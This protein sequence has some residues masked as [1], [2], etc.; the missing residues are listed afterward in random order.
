MS[1][2]RWLLLAATSLLL[3]AAGVVVAWRLNHAPA[4]RTDEPAPA[5]NGPGGPPP[6]PRLTFATPYRNV[7]P[8]VAYVGSAICAKCHGTIAAHFRRH[9]MGRSAASGAELLGE[10]I[11]VLPSGQEPLPGGAVVA[12]RL[13]RLEQYDKRRHD[14]FE[15]LG[16]EHKV[17]PRGGEIIHRVS[18]YDD[19][20]QLVTALEEPVY[21][22]LGSGTRGRT[23]VV[24]RGDALFESPISWYSQK[25]RWD[26]SPAYE[27][28]IFHQFERPITTECLF[29]HVNAVDPIQGTANRYRQPLVREPAIGCERCHGPGEL[30]VKFRKEHPQSDGKRD[31]TIVDPAKLEPTLRESV[32]EQCHLQG[33]VPVVRAGRQPF[34]YRPGL[35]YELFWSVFVPPEDQSDHHKS[36]TT[37]EQMHASRCFQKSQGALGC[38][39]CHDPHE[40]PTPEERVAYY[41]LRCQQCHGNRPEKGTGPLNA[42]VP[43]PS[44]AGRALPHA[45]ECS[46]DVSV[47]QQNG[48]NCIACH[49]APL[50]S[51]DIPHTANSD[52]RV[53]RRP[54]PT[55]GQ[56]APPPTPG[57]GPPLVAFH[58]DRLS[59][60]SRGV[61]RDLG[62]AL[63]QV[64]R[65][66][67][68]RNA[69]V[70]AVSLLEAAVK[71]WPDDRDALEALTTVLGTPGLG[72][73]NEA[74]AL[75]DDLANRTPP[76]EK[77]LLRAAEVAEHLERLPKATD[78]Y[79]RALALNSNRAET[80]AKLGRVLVARGDWAGAVPELDAALRLNP[81]DTEARE[82]LV[83]AFIKLGKRDRAR[84][85]FDR[86]L[87]FNPPKPDLLKSWFED[88][89]REAG[90]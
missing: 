75:L 70:A 53:L 46:E 8:D 16:L 49:M 57:G 19:R 7:R 2:R 42:G 31:F 35:P 27:Q 85:E 87:R 76:S 79:R 67:R 54:D 5:A 68:D 41:R 48:D 13:A 59:P 4:E 26:L 77:I 81:F 74:I 10:L 73:S 18:R 71:D 82:R 51:S 86:L 50:T 78:Y 83:Y 6:D 3:I 89:V 88:H 36:V 90:P 14:P 84:E 9:P 40:L 60:N 62:I 28:G 45:P 22:A 38:I 64:A 55:R 69:A 21:L 72:R 56:P 61:N 30:H 66:Q 43:S 1:T 11:G 37:V 52:H 34:D 29:C 12:S 65:Y 33:R 44:P 24:A 20:H 47:R 23:Y 39:S 15:A 63:V 80:H 25:H 58:R 17:E 32:C